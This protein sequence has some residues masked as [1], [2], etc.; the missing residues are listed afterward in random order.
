MTVTPETPMSERFAAMMAQWPTLA[1]ALA[2]M[3][4]TRLFRVAAGDSCPL[5]GGSSLL[6]VGSILHAGEGE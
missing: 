3:D 6:N 4:C 5:C 2:C 1:E